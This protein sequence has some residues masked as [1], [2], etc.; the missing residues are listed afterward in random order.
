MVD[1]RLLHDRVVRVLLVRSDND[2]GDGGRRV[3]PLVLMERTRRRRRGPPPLSQH[4][5]HLLLAALPLRVETFLLACARRV[6]LLLLPLKRP[7]PHLALR[8]RSPLRI[9]HRKLVR[10]VPIP[11]SLLCPLP[12][13]PHWLLLIQRLVNVDR[14]I[15]AFCPILSVLN[16]LHVRVPLAC[17]FLAR[18]LQLALRRAGDVRV[19]SPPHARLD[20]RLLERRR[21]ACGRCACALQR[22][23]MMRLNTQSPQ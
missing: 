6:K 23:P 11:P 20:A 5:A 9:H 8:R 21:R 16:R 13:L 14:L 18:A 10:V 12:R 15:R 7:P 4:A 1:R 17:L 2:V 3:S 22:N 19:L